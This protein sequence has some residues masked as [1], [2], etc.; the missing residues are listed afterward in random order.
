MAA[1]RT[2]TKEDVKNA[3]AA[4]EEKQRELDIT[5]EQLKQK[6]KL[7]QKDKDHLKSLQKERDLEQEILDIAEKENKAADE[8]AAKKKKEKEDLKEMRDIGVEIT[9][10]MQEQE[11][12]QGKTNAASK[13]YFDNW[14][15]LEGE[16]TKLG[17]TAG[18]I[19]KKRLGVVRTGIP[20]MQNIYSL[21][22]SVG[23][24][25]FIS[26][27][28]SKQIAEAKRLG[29]KSTQKALELAQKVNDANKRAH[30]QIEAAGKALLLPFEKLDSLV[31][32]LPFGE[33]VSKALGIEDAGERAVKAFKEYVSLKWMGPGEVSPTE[34]M[35]SKGQMTGVGGKAWQRDEKM[36]EAGEWEREA[37]PAGKSMAQK[38]QEKFKN[39]GDAIGNMT[40]KGMGDKLKSGA[41]NLAKILIQK[42]ILRHLQG[43]F[44]EI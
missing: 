6:N 12:A 5:T 8:K 35:G 11:K 19:R 17:K 29:L 4:R 2:Y 14:I 38:I 22:E 15:S 7:T 37:E 41:K 32:K 42:H 39:V 28:L 9:G 34:V 33:L 25:E 26:Y 10:I 1:K 16:I 23:T 43:N 30:E 27:N 18:P 3:K 36:I 24:E 44:Q 31:R 21:T 13:V 20:I 40:L